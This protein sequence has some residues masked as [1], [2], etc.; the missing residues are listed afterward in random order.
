MSRSL[1]EALL[2][3]Q[4]GDD[5]GAQTTGRTGDCGP[6]SQSWSDVPR[7]LAWLSCKGRGLCPSCGAKRAAEF[8]APK[9]LR[10][11]FMH[12]RELLG[13]LCTAAWQTVRELMALAADQEKG[14]L[15][16]SASSRR[17]ALTTNPSRSR[18]LSVS[19]NT[20][21]FGSMKSLNP[22]PPLSPS[23]CGLW[24]LPYTKPHRPDVAAFLVAN[25]LL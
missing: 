17:Q 25:R 18:T 6:R 7:P 9:M 14:F 4:F 16:D 13:P 19:A 22:N 23:G 15:F 11:Y 3:R 21:F 1:A 12:H 5:P 20:T 2:D 24:L 10:P 8:A